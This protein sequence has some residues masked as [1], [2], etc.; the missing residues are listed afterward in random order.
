MLKDTVDQ[1]IQFRA[2]N[3]NELYDNIVGPKLENGTLDEIGEAYQEYIQ[4]LEHF[5]VFAYRRTLDVI[6]KQDEETIAIYQDLFDAIPDYVNYRNNFQT[7]IKE[8][9]E[10]DGDMASKQAQIDSLDFNRTQAHNRV[11]MLFNNMNKLAEDNNIAYPYPYPPTHTFDKNNTFDRET[12]ATILGM[13]ETLMETVNNFVQ[14]KEVQKVDYKTM[15]PTQ[16]L[17]H[18]TNQAEDVSLNTLFENIQL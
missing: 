9:M 11:I 12:V 10:N 3:Q 8:I 6:L 14:S 1:Q 17:R 7:K 13:N 16:M 5:D 18:I 2:K 4:R 15:T